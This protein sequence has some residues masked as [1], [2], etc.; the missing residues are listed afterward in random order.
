MASHKPPQ[1]REIAIR[2]CAACDQWN[3][4]WIFGYDFLELSVMKS[5]TCVIKPSLC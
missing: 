4:S 1:I 2:G 5:G 3:S